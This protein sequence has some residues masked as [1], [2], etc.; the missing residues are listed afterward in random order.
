MAILA[1]SCMLS[2][3]IMQGETKEISHLGLVAAVIHE[4]GLVDIVDQ[5]IPISSEKGAK[6][7]MGERLFGMILNALGQYRYTVIYGS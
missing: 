6:L 2:A 5:I 3:M 1:V 4:L 7:S